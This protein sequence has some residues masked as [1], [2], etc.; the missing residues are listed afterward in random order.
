M[1]G[2]A[3]SEKPGPYRLKGGHLG[4]VVRAGVVDSHATGLAI[5]P[6]IWDLGHPLERAVLRLEV[7]IRRP[8]VGKVLAEAAR[9]AVG[10][11]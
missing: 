5:V 6:T 9:R 1:L 4:A 10:K 11:L 3:D 8:V 2:E 7:E